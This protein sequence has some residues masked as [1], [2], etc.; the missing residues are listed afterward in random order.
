VENMQMVYYV[1]RKKCIQLIFV[2][3][4]IVT[5]SQTSV[6]AIRNNETTIPKETLPRI[7]LSQHQNVQQL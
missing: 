5:V 3:K 2:G 6:E 1:K 4:P 7:S